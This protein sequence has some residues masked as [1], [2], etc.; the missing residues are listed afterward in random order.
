RS[1]STGRTVG[2]VS[3]SSV[4]T[5]P[6]YRAVSGASPHFFLTCGKLRPPCWFEH[7]YYMPEWTI[8]GL[9][10]SLGRV[11]SFGRCSQALGSLKPR[12][13]WRCLSFVSRLGAWFAGFGSGCG[14]ADDR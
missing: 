11:L 12:V 2:G 6:G 8:F 4:V 13:R 10:C 7:V 3:G 14:R 5:C 1:L 9:C